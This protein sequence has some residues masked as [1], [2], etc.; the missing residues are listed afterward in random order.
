MPD[1]NGVMTIDEVARYLRVARST[2]YRQAREGRIP[3]RRV[4][5]RWRFSRRAIDRWL[6]AQGGP[7]P[8]L[9]YAGVFRKDETLD[10]IVAE[11]YQQR[12]RP[13]VSD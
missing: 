11:I 6:Q 2:V 10:E 13:L 8:V 3:T 9:K 12:G 7:P 4:G 5:R 1:E